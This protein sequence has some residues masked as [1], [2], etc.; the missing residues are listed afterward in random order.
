MKIRAALLEEFGKPMAIRE[1]DLA[2]PQPGEVLVKIEACALNFADLLLC[3]GRYQ[4]KLAP[5]FTPGLEVA[6]RVVALGA[7]V[8]GPP[9]GTPVAVTTRGGGLAEYGVFPALQAV[10]LP[11]DMPIEQGAAFQVAMDRTWTPLIATR[12]GNFLSV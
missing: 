10:I 1:L 2:P 5:P 12:T 3:E 7:G 6:G 8:S 11:A 9:E 4:E